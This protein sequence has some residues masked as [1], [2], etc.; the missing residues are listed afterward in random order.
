M[1]CLGL[2]KVQKEIKEVVEMGLTEKQKRFV[3]YYI[4]TGNAT[5]AARRAGYQSKS[6]HGYESIGN[7]NL[8]KLEAEIKER[9]ESKEDDRIAKQ[10]EVLRYLTS[11]MRREHAENVV[12]T[13]MEE[14][15]TFVPDEHGTMRKQTI[16]H[17]VP[18]VV[19]IPAKLSDANKA[20]ELLGKRYCLWTDKVD[21]AGD[22]SVVIRYDYG[23]DGI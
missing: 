1:W 15:T 10:D 11:V 5:E 12:V 2:G 20:A 4:E 14:Q 17:E 19:E 23:D 16:K 8:R 22:V 21:V 3:D 13:L 6:E 7:E 18:Q 9:L